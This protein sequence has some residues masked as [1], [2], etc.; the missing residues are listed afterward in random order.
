MV[1]LLDKVKV[2]QKVGD[3]T[4]TYVGT[5]TFAGDRILQIETA[6]GRLYTFSRDVSHIPAL[7]QTVEVL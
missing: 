4:R 5:L 6:S 2:T 7:T 1:T 3:E